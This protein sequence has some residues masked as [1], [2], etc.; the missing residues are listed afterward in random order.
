MIVIQRLV[1]TAELFLNCL[2]TLISLVL[3]QRTATDCS[4]CI[5]KKKRY[6]NFTDERK[7]LYK[8]IPAGKIHVFTELYS[9]LILLGTGSL[10]HTSQS[11][12]S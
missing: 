3:S 10:C 12:N 5:E 1:G 11:Y 6:L 8:S 4:K 7:A 2:R 9:G